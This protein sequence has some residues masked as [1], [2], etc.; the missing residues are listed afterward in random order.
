VTENALARARA[1]DEQAFAVLTDPY[2]RELQLHCYRIL[3][4][5][6]DAEDA[7][8]ETLLAAWRAL[9]TFEERSPLRSWLYRIATNRCL[10]ML[11]DGARRPTPAIGSSG[12]PFT[13]PEPTRYAE[14]L[15]LEPYPDV[16]LEGIADA[17]PGPDARYE[18]REA[19]SLAFLSA[20]HRLP[21]R[22]RAV[23][24][25]RDVLGFSAAEVADM[26]D[27]TQTSVNSALIRSR[28]TVDERG[29]QDRSRVPLPD[30][31]QEQELVARFADAFEHGDIDPLVELL[32][33]DAWITM[34]P[35]PFEYQGHAAI[36]HFLSNAFAGNWDHPH[37]LIATRANTQPAFVHYAKDP[38]AEIGRARSLFV[39]TLDRD[40]ISHIARFA[41]TNALGHFGLPR[42]I[43]W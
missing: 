12:L 20:L 18:T 21:P 6:Q 36:R 15:W 3:G 7:V 14:A 37:R 35:E 38:H 5:V 29:Q 30:S 9:D 19:V 1:G 17:G 26:L 24:V 31:V 2:R 11:R 41:P 16:L 32:T 39:L 43:P 23:L 34:P 27:T 10:N 8:Q 25:L 13:P 42:T 28:S 4:Q 33:E 22:Q 40:H